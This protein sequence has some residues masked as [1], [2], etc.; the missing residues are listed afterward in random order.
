MQEWFFWGG[1][2]TWNIIIDVYIF[3]KG[4]NSINA[5]NKENLVGPPSAWLK[6]YIDFNKNKR[7]NA[8]NSVEKDFFK[9]MNNSVFGKTM[10]NIPKRVN[11]NLETDEKK[12]MILASKPTNVISK[13]CIKI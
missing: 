4:K 10:E 5:E 11:D 3:T 12:I 13:I 8:K 2:I 1:W 7:T 9:L 6:Q